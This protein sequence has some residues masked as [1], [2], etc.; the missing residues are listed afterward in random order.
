MKERRDAPDPM[1][2]FRAI[3]LIITQRGEAQV[4]LKAVRSIQQE[5][6]AGANPQIQ[7]WQ[8]QFE[9]RLK[10][11][12]NHVNEQLRFLTISYCYMLRN[13]SFHADK[14]YPVFGLFDESGKSTEDVLTRLLLYVIRDLIAEIA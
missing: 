7:Q 11:K 4:K 6:K 5:K 14:P 3:A 10:R 8:T 2:A 12:S 13:R 1:K 9:K